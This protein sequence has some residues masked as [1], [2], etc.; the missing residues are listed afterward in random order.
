MIELRPMSALKGARTLFITLPVTWRENVGLEAR[1][2]IRCFVDNEKRL[3]LEAPGKG[4]DRK[5]YEQ[6]SSA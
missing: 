2:K 5:I 4:S 1:D 6:V 3:I